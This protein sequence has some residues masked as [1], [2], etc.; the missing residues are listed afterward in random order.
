MGRGG[1]GE[2]G[3]ATR[4]VLLAAARRNGEDRKNDDAR[5]RADERIGIYADD[6]AGEVFYDAEEH[7]FA[8]AERGAF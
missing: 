6:D 2:A 4:G 8:C 3:E 5:F 1:R 7:A